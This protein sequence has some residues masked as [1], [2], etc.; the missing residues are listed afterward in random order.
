MHSNSTRLP[1]S[2]PSYSLLPSQAEPSQRRPDPAPGGTTQSALPRPPSIP[3]S[4]RSA[5][6]S[7]APRQALPQA[8]PPAPIP[9][10]PPA[11]AP[12]P[13]PS[14]PQDVLNHIAHLSVDRNDIPAASAAQ[15]ARLGTVDRA[16]QVAAQSAQ[17]RHPKVAL[18]AAGEK[19]VRAAANAMEEIRKAKEARADAPMGAL[20]G[21]ARLRLAAVIESMPDVALDLRRI[22]PPMSTE[23]VAVLREHPG[24]KTLSVT[25]PP[26]ALDMKGVMN[27]LA[28][29]PGVLRSLD[30]HGTLSNTHGPDPAQLLRVLKA[31]PGLEELDLSHT[32]L[33]PGP[34]INGALASLPHLHSLSLAG[35]TLGA[36][37]AERLAETLSKN[38][39]LRHLDLSQNQI[40]DAGAQALAHHLLGGQAPLPLESLLLNDNRIG[41][42]GGQALAASLERPPGAPAEGSLRRLSLARNDLGDATA[43]DLASAIRSHPALKE[44]DLEKTGLSAAGTGPV[45]QALDHLPSLQALSLRSNT[46]NPQGFTDLSVV[47]LERPQLQKLNLRGTQMSAN[48]LH[49]LQPTLQELTGMKHLDLSNNTLGNGAA[50]LGNALQAMPGLQTLE[51]QAT[52]LTPPRMQQLANGLQH[53]TGL[54]ELNLQL[55]NL[56]GAGAHD[57]ATVLRQMPHLEKLNVSHC[58]LDTA[59]MEELVPP[60]RD[61]QNLQVLRMVQGNN[62]FSEAELRA[63]VPRPHFRD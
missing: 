25:L 63:Q 22:L 51:L 11:P 28:E 53:C 37:G 10:L 17:D 1:T 24:L 43:P 48:D 41:P 15:L 36:A 12:A 45:I 23:I 54:R 59:A 20:L 32:P 6:G 26:D 8:P 46:L 21:I 5:A 2:G 39:Q 52:G 40:G 33:P 55:N 56:G 9:L 49:T 34:A 30:L 7:T 19:L 16:F 38:T 42:V 27:L 61:A 62:G 18:A 13:L 3:G 47:L 50:G 60:L 44:L 35:C 31:Q 29:R 58:R 4:P 14:L 57:L